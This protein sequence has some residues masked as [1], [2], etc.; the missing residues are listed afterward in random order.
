MLELQARSRLAVA[1]QFISVDEL[2]HK[3]IR[4]SGWEF[5]VIWGENAFPKFLRVNG[6]V[7][8]QWSLNEVEY[9]GSYLFSLPPV[10][11]GM[12]RIEVEPFSGTSL[13]KI[14]EVITG[15][16]LPELHLKEIIDWHR[17]FCGKVA[18]FPGQ[19]GDVTVLTQIT[20]DLFRMVSD[21]ISLDQDDDIPAGKRSELAELFEKVL[22]SPRSRLIDENFL[23]APGEI[24]R[25]TPTTID[26]FIRHPETWHSRYNTISKVEPVKLLD[27]RTIEN[28]DVYENRFVL[29]FLEKLDELLHSL[30]YRYKQAADHLAMQLPV[31]EMQANYGWSID[32]NKLT[33]LKS[34]QDEV[35]REFAG[36]KRLR[37]VV[38]QVKSN[39]LF[40]SVRTLT[41]PP[42]ANT[43]LSMHP[44]YGRLYRLYEEIIGQSFFQKQ[45]NWLDEAKRADLLQIYQQYCLIVLVQTLEDSKFELVESSL[46]SPSIFDNS[47]ESASTGENWRLK[48]VHQLYRDTDRCPV[49]K[50][51][52]VGLPQYEALRGALRLEFELTSTPA[53]APETKSKEYVW[54]IPD[55]TWWGATRG[56]T[57]DVAPNEKQAALH[58]VYRQ[59]QD[60]QTRLAPASEA[61]PQ[62][63]RRRGA[64]DTV[65]E[66]PQ[67][68]LTVLLLHPT[69]PDDFDNK[70]GYQSLR[71]LLNQGDNFVTATEYESFGGYKI[72]CLPIYPGG[73]AGFRSLLRLKR[74][75][76]IHL[77]RIGLEDLCW[78]CFT[79]SKYKLNN[80]QKH[81]ECLNSGCGLRWGEVKCKHCGHRYVKMTTPTTA[82]KKHSISLENVSADSSK[83]IVNSEILEGQLTVSSACE[84]IDRAGDFWAICPY[85]G[86]CEKETSTGKCRRCRER[87]K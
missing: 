61:K 65:D 10:I 47:V 62:K 11:R 23:V 40:S 77:F 60:I 51:T 3:P 32:D 59:L 33:Q 4:A 52:Y 26:Y 70:L 39:P 21:E 82:V 36:L 13:L 18:L 49:V 53:Q 30:M 2:M 25:I 78:K 14:L 24:Q 48:F 12:A 27:E 44:V 45:L 85:C 75:I 15:Y 22:R 8:R 35:L 66:V 86:H 84:N 74:L 9:Q 81:Y 41:R 76:R 46:V 29:H 68:E 5:A 42:K 17:D 67:P 69:P 58:D 73:G 56:E 6:V 54:L 7:L 55:A 34:Q 37:N 79:K 64:Q 38:R 71:L 63:K 87:A 80:G 72:G 1:S 83:A 16:Q 19:T 20:S 50:V 31:S 28:F 43:T 57:K